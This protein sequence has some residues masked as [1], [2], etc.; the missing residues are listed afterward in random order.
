M[1]IWLMKMTTVFVFETIAVSLRRA[2]DMRRAWRPT[3]CW[4]I[5]P[6]ISARGVKA[7]T[8]SMTITSTALERTSDSTISSACSPVSGWEMSRSSILTPIFFAY[9]G[10]S[11]CSASTYAA[12]PPFFCASRTMCKAKVV[13]PELSGPNISMILPRGT[14][15]TPS[16]ASSDTEPVG[17]TST[18]TRRA[19]PSFMIA[20]SPNFSRIS[21]TVDSRSFV[22]SNFSLSSFITCLLFNKY[23]PYHRLLF[24]KTVAGHKFKLMRALRQ[25]YS[26]IKVTAFIKRKLAAI[27]C[28]TA[29]F[30]RTTTH[31]YR[32]TFVSC[33]I[34][35]LY[36]TKYRRSGKGYEPYA[37]EARDKHQNTHGSPDANPA[38]RERKRSRI[39]DI[40]YK[41]SRRGAYIGKSGFP[42]LIK[43]I[44]QK[45]RIFHAAHANHSFE[46]PL[47]VYFCR[48]CTPIPALKRT[49][50]TRRN[51][52]M[53]SERFV[54]HTHL[55]AGL[56]EPLSKQG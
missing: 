22:L 25:F 49:D 24:A 42:F 34:L 40:F 16:A 11:A 30:L 41:R 33:V 12:M 36:K 20:P 48:K 4:P 43:R 26:F 35:G 52:R 29:F 15:P 38:G 32:K 10:S 53:P 13:L 6:S 19:S 28:Q 31:G 54:C 37:P 14:P 46:R 7:A 45:I 1:R 47:R 5:S 50:I 39:H 8:E 2:C 27:D 21:L 18:S 44:D 3:C 9:S 55:L 23:M 51:T 56:P 17:M